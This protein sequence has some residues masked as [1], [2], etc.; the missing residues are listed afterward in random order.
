MVVNISFFFI[1]LKILFWSNLH[2]QHGAQTHDRK[3]KSQM[4]YWLSQ[5]GTLV[6][7]SKLQN[8]T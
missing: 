1:F 5:A 7:I 8:L 3:I 6:N 4:R 2:T